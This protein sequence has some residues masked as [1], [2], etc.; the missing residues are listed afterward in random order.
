MDSKKSMAVM[1]LKYKKQVVKLVF[2]AQ[3]SDMKEMVRDK[4]KTSG[5]L[6]FLYSVSSTMIGVEKLKMDET[7]LLFSQNVICCGRHNAF[8][9]F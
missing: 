2:S 3:N 6:V 5:L 1:L 4:G 9:C 8:L 7:C